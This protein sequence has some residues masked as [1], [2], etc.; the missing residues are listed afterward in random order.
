MKLPY[1]N[2]AII[3]RKKL[4]H[5]LLNLEHKDG[6]SKAKFFRGI[7]FSEINLD[8]FEQELLKVAKE[9]KVTLVNKSKSKRVKYDPVIKYSIIGSI[10]AP[11]GKR[12]M[13]ETGWVRE[14][15]KKIPRLT[16]AYAYSIIRKRKEK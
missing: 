12:Y 13:V 2:N 7:G 3:P 9:N 4:T 11:N 8:K 15:G 5:Y 10:N 16:S 1:R 6:K 14:T